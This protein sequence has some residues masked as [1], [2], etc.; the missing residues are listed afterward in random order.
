VLGTERMHNE[1]N[2]YEYVPRLLA[3]PFANVWDEKHFII[4]AP[5]AYTE[6][7]ESF[8]HWLLLHHTDEIFFFI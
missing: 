6:I 1:S 7:I 2:R 5:V 4:V 3:S 8:K